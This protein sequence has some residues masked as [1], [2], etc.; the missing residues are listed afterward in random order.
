MVQPMTGSAHADGWFIHRFSPCRQL[1]LPTSLK[2]M[3]LLNSATVDSA[4]ASSGI[5]RIVVLAHDLIL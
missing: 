2:T 1:V 5:L 3:S 4:Y